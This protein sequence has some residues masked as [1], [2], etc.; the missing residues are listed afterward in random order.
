MKTYLNVMMLVTSVAVTSYGAQAQAVY[1]TGGTG[2]SMKMSGTSTFHDWTM[3]SKDFTGDAQFGL[4]GKQLATVKSLTFTLPVE[5][6][7]SN[8]KGLDKNAYHALKSQQYKNIVYKLLAAQ[9][10]PGSGSKCVV[11]TKGDLTIAGVTKE[12]NMDVYCTVNNDA[13]ITCT[14]SDKVKMTDYKVD[15]PKFMMGAMTTGDN[16]TLDFTAV[17]RQ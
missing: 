8:E 9:V 16:I 15:P 11:K 14:G 6:L 17:Y 7:K 3:N 10:L 2:N 4:T 13:S 1:K 5:D 12:I